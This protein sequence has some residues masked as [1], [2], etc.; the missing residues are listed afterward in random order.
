MR[1][2]GQHISGRAQTGTDLEIPHSRRMMIA[3]D[4]PCHL[5]KAETLTP[6]H[7][8]NRIGIRQ[9]GPFAASLRIPEIAA[10]PQSFR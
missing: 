3:L 4:S 2:P 6:D 5:H 1:L 7:E 10:A 9:R 8:A